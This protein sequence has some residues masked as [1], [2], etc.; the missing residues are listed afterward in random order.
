MARN[1]EY[2]RE[3]WLVDSIRLEGARDI[4]RTA[5]A[6]LLRLA[7]GI[8]LFLAL[9]ASAAYADPVLP[10]PINSIVRPNGVLPV[11]DSAP[12]GLF[13]FKGNDVGTV[14]GRRSYPV[15]GG[16]VVTSLFGKQTWVALDMGGGRTGWIFTGADQYPLQ[17]V[18]VVR[19]GANR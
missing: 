19:F 3:G 17:N 16:K 11:R 8:F 12:Q 1:T 13:A 9:S 14:D 2:S 4:A 7:A 15:V 6:K 10:L 18:T 5:A